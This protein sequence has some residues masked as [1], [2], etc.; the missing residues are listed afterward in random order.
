[1][2]WVT[3]AAGRGKEAVRP[4]ESS[5]KTA[6]LRAVLAAV[7]NVLTQEPRIG[8]ALMFGSRARGEAHAG[9]DLDLAI[10]GLPR[11]FTTLELGSLMSR[12]E[13]AAGMPVD[14]VD[15]DHCPPS[16]AFRI[17]RDG[18]VLVERDSNG[19]ADRRA[20]AVLEYLD[21]QPFERIFTVAP[22]AER[23]HD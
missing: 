22:T 13:A 2:Q 8:Y 9:S 6:R 23:T 14:L 10:G 12:L 11:P 3:A 4:V 17:L 1:M 16:L 15:L 5:R 19:L 21:W 7:S 20:R 18:R